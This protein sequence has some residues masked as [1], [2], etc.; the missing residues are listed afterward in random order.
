MSPIAGQVSKAAAP[1]SDLSKVID[2]AKS[3][4][5]SKKKYDKQILTAIN[6]LETSMLN[7]QEITKGIKKSMQKPKE[8]NS[9][10]G[11]SQ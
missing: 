5:D 8:N 2:K 10:S 1:V 7:L 6:S 9:K 11:N 4:A 3:L